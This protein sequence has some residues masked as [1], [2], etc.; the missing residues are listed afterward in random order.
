MT[1]LASFANPISVI[2]RSPTSGVF[3]TNQFVGDK[4]GFVQRCSESG[5]AIQGIPFPLRACP[6]LSRRRNCMTSMSSISK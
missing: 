1:T 6:T 2:Q 3:G 5:T 4:E